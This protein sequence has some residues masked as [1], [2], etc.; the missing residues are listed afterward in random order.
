MAALAVLFASATLFAPTP[1]LA[2]S[3]APPSNALIPMFW[4][5]LAATVALL[6]PAGLVLIGVAG[7]E[8]ER[9]WNAALAAVGAISL[10]AL[11]YWSVGFALH[12]GGIG[13]LYVRPE[14]RGLVWEW[15]PLPPDWGVG[16]GAAGLSGWFLAGADM[17]ALVYALFLAHLPWL[18]VVT[19]LPVMALRGR[20][21]WLATLAIALLMGGIV[22]PL[23]GNWVQGGGWLSALGRNLNLGHGFVDAGGA[24]A[25]FLLAAAF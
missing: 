6:V 11:A 24:G 9:A 20:A 22:Y 2:Q 23:A 25:V 18:F 19:L 10:A 4:F 14:L 15:S 1:A 3:G 7:L 12:F 17:T 21:P 5:L 8:R 13:L 16:W